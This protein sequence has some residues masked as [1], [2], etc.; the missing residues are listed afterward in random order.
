MR[1][2]TKYSRTLVSTLALLACL[3]DPL[4]AFAELPR[5]IPRFPLNESGLL[6]ERP[7]RSGASFD[8]TGRGAAAFGHEDGTFEAWIHPLEILRDFSLSFQIEGQPHDIEGRTIVSRVRVRPESTT[9]VYTHAAFTVRQTLFVPRSAMGLVMLLDIDC[10]RPLRVFAS[11]RPTLAPMWPAG[12][13]TPWI[14]WDHQ[15]RAYALSESGGR[16]AAL[17]G[18]PGAEPLSIEPYLEGPSK[19]PLRFAIDAKL[20]DTRKSLIP[21]VMTG[22]VSGLASA[23]QVYDDL[24]NTTIERYDEKVR[25]FVDLL[26]RTSEIDTP[27]DRLDMAF[28]WARVGIDQGFVT[29]PMLG[30]GLVAGFGAAGPSERPGYAWFFGR[31]ALWTSLA[32]NAYGDFGAAQRALDFLQKFQRS[33]GKIPHE[34]SQSASLVPWFSNYPYPWSSADASP[35]FVI[36][37]HDAFESTGDLDAL[38]ARWDAILR[39]WTFSASTDTDGDGLIENA[40]AGHG[41][42]E[43][44]ALLPV[45]EEIY[46]QG[47]WIQA[48]EALAAM[49]HALGEDVLAARAKDTAERARAASEATY[50]LP[51]KDHYA[52]ATRRAQG[53]DVLVEEDTVFPAV[54][55]LF[56]LFDDSRAQKQLDHLGAL[57]IATDW[58]A[59]SLS[60]ESALYDPLSYHHGSVWPLFSGWLSLSAYRYGRPSIGHQALYASALLTE[61]GSLGAVPELLS[62]AYRTAFARTVPHQIWSQ[63]MV[64]LPALRGLFGIEVKDAA[65]TLRFAPSLP[66]NWDHVSVR[67]VAVGPG[68]YDLSL[69]RAGGEISIS[70]T[71]SAGGAKTRLSSLE[72]APALPLD[73]EV[74]EVLVNGRAHAF[75]SRRLGDVER[76]EI[77]IAPPDDDMQIVIRLKPGT[78]VFVAYEMPEEGARSQGLRVLRARTEGG[79]L[80]LLLEG[81]A[82]RSYT[83]YARTPRRIEAADGVR[84][85]QSGDG[86]STLIVDFAADGNG[87]VR[88]HLRL[89]LSDES[90]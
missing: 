5:L 55:L 49:A 78:R 18:A 46:L 60:S 83:L 43:G 54:P 35:L 61:A 50:W 2:Q 41:W 71:R 87:P 23:E 10:T 32:L 20:E 64:A 62:G 90:P 1:G 65:K 86:G 89:A 63:A 11:L 72:I 75:A 8:V 66:A 44:G 42:V 37:Q 16:F 22:S 77:R 82:G 59:R 53:A 67:R 73:A 39:A 56:G 58:G 31:D 19:E 28:R 21:I 4:S 40:G 3:F 79:T 84:V 69:S 45:H 57:S 80:D 29:N 25:H 36:A 27:D 33:D 70:V 13:V 88:R 34:I 68:H 48:S 81:M 30:T 17:I 15:R 52:F 14:V 9:F 26:A 38:R 76:P 6:L 85:V 7:V 12:R 47:L 51:S 74:L 24:M